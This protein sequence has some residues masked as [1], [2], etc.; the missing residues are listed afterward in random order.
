MP[1]K[2]DDE[3][4]GASLWR[5]AL[6]ATTL[7]WDLAVPIIA[8]TL[9]GYFLDKWLATGHTFTLGL[10]FLGIVVS[11]YNLWRFIQRDERK[12]KKLK[13]ESAG[14]AEEDKEH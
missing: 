1:K 3:K 5:E 11:Y 10:L 14:E 6:L 13:N 4:T 12:N 9:A 2:D 8:G 7:G